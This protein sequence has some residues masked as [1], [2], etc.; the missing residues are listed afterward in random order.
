MLCNFPISP[1]FEERHI[2]YPSPNP[3][4][5]IVFECDGARVLALDFEPVL[6]ESLN[7]S[8]SIST[9]VVHHLPQF[10]LSTVGRDIAD[11]HGSYFAG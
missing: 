6:G 9:R 2:T 3:C 7:P 4:P 11:W 10:R 8:R 1:Q 5:R